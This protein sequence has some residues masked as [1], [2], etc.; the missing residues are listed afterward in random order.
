VATHGLFTETTIRNLRHPK[1][2]RIIV[3][4]SV[5]QPGKVKRRLPLEIVS[6]DELLAAAIREISIERGSVSKLFTDSM[7]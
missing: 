7:A 6:I 3:T 4:D 2:K 1:V 5:P